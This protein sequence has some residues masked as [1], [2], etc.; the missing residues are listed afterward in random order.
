MRNVSLDLGDHDDKKK[1]HKTLPNTDFVS[2][3]VSN[4]ILTFGRTCTSTIQK[5][6][7]DIAVL[8]NLLCT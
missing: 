7:L 6:V 1:G 5:A 3:N 4:R 2:P 8:C